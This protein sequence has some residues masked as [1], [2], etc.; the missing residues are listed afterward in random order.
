MKVDTDADKTELGDKS[1]D[2]SHVSSSSSYTRTFAQ[3]LG[4]K[5]QRSFTGNSSLY[6]F[7]EPSSGNHERKLWPV[8]L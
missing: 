4:K 3:Y 1:I 8:I 7:T 2:G 5:L 6:D